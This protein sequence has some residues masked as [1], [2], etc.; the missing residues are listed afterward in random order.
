M[1]FNPIGIKL[2]KLLDWKPTSLPI[3]MIVPLLNKVR[4]S[5]YRQA[6]MLYETARKYGFENAEA[7]HLF[8]RNKHF[9]RSFRVFCDIC[10]FI[11]DNKISIKQYFRYH[12]FRTNYKYRW[13]YYFKI[14][15]SKILNFGVKCWSNFLNKLPIPNHPKFTYSKDIR[16]AICDRYFYIRDVKNWP[17]LRK[18]EQWINFTTFWLR[19]ANGEELKQYANQLSHISQSTLKKIL[20]EDPRYSPKKPK[21]LKKDH[22]LRDKPKP[23]GWIQLDVKVYGRLQT[24]RG[25][26]VYQIDAIDL[27]SRVTKGHILFAQTT[28]EIMK[29]VEQMKQEFEDEGIKFKIIQTDNAMVFK[30]INFVTSNEFNQWCKN[31]GIKHLLIP[32]GEPECNGCIERF[33]E[34]ID[35]ELV[36]TLQEIKVLDQLEQALQ[37]YLYKY[38]NHRYHHYCELKDKPL[39][40]QYMKP[41]DSI[42]YFACIMNKLGCAKR[43]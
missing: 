1:Y 33:H 4:D 36:Y 11:Y 32:L 14:T 16:K 30:H 28:Q 27:Q 6:N 38:N 20:K 25:K 12:N 3:K 35:K 17:K 5:F 26:Y 43:L 18:S 7:M 13:F 34:T 21:R 42:K 29:K 22:P 31:L 2:P 39:K 24:G 9:E 41:V 8:L 19:L 10:E 15:I 23:P 40:Q 37:T